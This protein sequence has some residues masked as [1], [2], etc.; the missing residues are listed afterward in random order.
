MVRSTPVDQT[1]A[2][3]RP[4]PAGLDVRMVRAGWSTIALFTT[5]VLASGLLV[6][7][8]GDAP[9]TSSDLVDGRALYLRRCASCHGSEGTGGV[10]GALAGRMV[11]RFPDAS[12]EIALVADGRG[13]MPAFRSVLTDAEIAAVVDYTRTG[14]NG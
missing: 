5:A 9:A 12:D 2:L 6:A 1:T 11:G 4:P 3:A 8:S 10:G 14:L 13:T 7:C